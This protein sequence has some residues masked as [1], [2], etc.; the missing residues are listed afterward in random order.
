[1]NEQTE[2][3]QTEPVEVGL[4]RF[5]DAGSTPAAASETGAPSWFAGKNGRFNFVFELNG[6]H[7]EARE[8]DRAQVK[9]T[10]KRVREIGKQSKEI[11]RENTRLDLKIR[12]LQAQRDELLGGDDADFDAIEKLDDEI[13]RHEDAIEALADKSEPLL[14][15]QAKIYE[16]VV[17]QSLTRW[18]L[19]EELSPE[20]I[21]ALSMTAK[22]NIGDIVL[23]KSIAGGDRANFTY[24]R[25]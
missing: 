21:A 18:D 4:N 5:G 10:T 9:A 6:Q 12:R 11:K 8:L 14:E 7:F 19:S 22:R 16:N 20:N 2:N 23:E 3:E 25:K 15:E 13:Y 24:R 1:M 17:G